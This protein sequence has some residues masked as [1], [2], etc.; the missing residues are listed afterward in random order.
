MSGLAMGELEMLRRDV[1][2]RA[3]VR[4]LEA[5]GDHAV[6]D[7]MARDPV[8]VLEDASLADAADLLCGSDISGL[9]VVDIDGRLVGVITERD[10]V[11]FRGNH[12]SP[13]DWRRRSMHDLMTIPAA[14][15]GADEPVGEAARRMTDL[16]VHR[17]FV[18]DEAQIPVGVIAASDVVTEIVEWEE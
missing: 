4:R 5:C 16:G 2:M 6:R 11:A 13:S 12:L 9:A 18:V 15:I 3:P 7:R 17:L 1:P 10:L 8:T 14:V